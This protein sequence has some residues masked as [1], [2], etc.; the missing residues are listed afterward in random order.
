MKV[1]VFRIA[2]LTYRDAWR[3]AQA[4]PVVLAIALLVCLVEAVV[5]DKF[6]HQSAPLRLAA[7]LLGMLIAGGLLTPFL[8]AVQRF[9]LLDEVATAY[10]IDV[11]HP[12]FQKYFI[13][14]A[15]L[16]LLFHAAF[17][18]DVL[19]ER[20]SGA[21]PW[22]VLV[23]WLGYFVVSL[24][25]TLLFPA[26]AID[27]AAARWATALQASSGSFWRIVGVYICVLVPIVP[28]MALSMGIESMREAAVVPNDLLNLIGGLVIGLVNFIN[29]LTWAVA[30]SHLFRVLEDKM[31]SGP[32]AGG[33][34]TAGR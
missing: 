21:K 4:M 9:I 5:T 19:F 30:A 22:F 34:P 12:R 15:L 27:A 18:G 32:V 24:R 14:A 16:V 3:V 20:G 17:L 31:R 13:N 29:Q 26:I 11:H 10:R 7:N 6:S 8:I 33:W 25:V 2:V 23:V 1:P 28:L